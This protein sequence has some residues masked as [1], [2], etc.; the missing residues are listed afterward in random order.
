MADILLL[1]EEISKEISEKLRLRLSGDEQK[2]LT[3]RHTENTE[4]YRLYLKG[5]YY[6]NKRTADGY[7]KGIDHFQQAIEKDSNYALAYTGLADSYMLFGRFGTVPPKES[8]AKA[9]AAATTALEIDDELAEA[10]TSLG[11]IKKEYDWDFPGR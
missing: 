9:K 2:R 3:K 11:Y 4:A 1:Q 5:R 8:M 6:W 7:Q 10:H